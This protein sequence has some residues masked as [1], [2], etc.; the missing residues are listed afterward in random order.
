[1]S[2]RTRQNDYDEL[3]DEAIVAICDA[4][5][6]GDGKH[7]PG[8][9]ISENARHHWEHAYAH[10]WSLNE[11]FNEED[12]NHLICRAVMLHAGRRRLRDGK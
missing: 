5:H 6:D 12:L 8:S 10:L 1:M 7:E 4:L 3:C 2:E 9:W 11:E